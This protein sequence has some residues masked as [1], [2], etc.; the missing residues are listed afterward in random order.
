MYKIQ[1]FA[2]LFIFSLLAS[3]TTEEELLQPNSLFEID[4]TLSL[5]VQVYD[6]EMVPV[7]GTVIVIGNASGRNW[8]GIHE[9][10]QATNSD[11]RTKIILPRSV[12]KS[13]LLDGGFIQAMPNAYFVGGYISITDLDELQVIKG[14]VEEKIEVEFL[15]SI[16][17]KSLLDESIVDASIKLTSANRHPLLSAFNS[18][19]SVD[20]VFELQ[21]GPDTYASPPTNS[22]GEVKLR[23]R[24]AGDNP[25]II[26][27]LS[28]YDRSTYTKEFFLIEE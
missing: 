13:D 16:D 4:R 11:G 14:E 20:G 7:E 26:I 18:A 2:I 19:T 5:D 10:G 15:K 25:S 6:H 28:R 3:C 9:C 12:S 27:E 23:F 22:R 24:K 17:Q 8:L 1:A 21:W